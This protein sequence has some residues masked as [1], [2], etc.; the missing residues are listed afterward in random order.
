MPV[1]ECHGFHPP[2]IAH[3]YDNSRNLAF[4]RSGGVR[5]KGQASL[6]PA[7]YGACPGA[8]RDSV[9]RASAASREAT[10]R[11]EA[12]L[13]PRRGATQCAPGVGVGGWV[14]LAGGWGVASCSWLGWRALCGAAARWRGRLLPRRRLAT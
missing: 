11:N 7:P 13:T 6:Q 10:P 9:S 2:I 12:P 1:I 14:S 5:N 3:Q 4:T 8:A